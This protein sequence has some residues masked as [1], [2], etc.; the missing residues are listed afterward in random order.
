MVR[1]TE[2]LIIIIIILKEEIQL[3]KAHVKLKLTVHVARYFIWE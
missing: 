3:I 1:R 2:V